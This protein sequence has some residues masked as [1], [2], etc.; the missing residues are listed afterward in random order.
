[1]DI[2][3]IR[4]IGKGIFRPEGVMALDDGT[5]LASDAQ[6]R[7]ARIKR[8]GETGFFGSV[9]G[10]PNGICIDKEGNCIIANIGNG[11]VQSLSPDGN[12]K[13]LMTEADG[14]SITAPNFPFVD[15]KDRL[16]VS[17]STDRETGEAILNPAPDGCIVMIENGSAR[18]VAKDIYFA[19]GIAIDQEEEYFYVAETTKKDVLRFKI[20][21]DG[22]LYDRAVY[23]PPVLDT[24]G[25]PD[26]I[27]F[28]E[29]GNLWITFPMSNAVAY[30]TPQVELRIFLKDP[31]GRFLRQPSNICFG[32]EDRR[33]AFIGSLDG[34]T[35]PYFRVPYPGM[36]LIHQS[37]HLDPAV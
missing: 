19:N 28:D 2:S 22:T 12:H 23:G 26:G 30:I 34:Q 14:K 33:T 37:R 11:Q 17:N 31:E 3:V 5:I 32:W 20:A 13:V 21:E 35:I 6:G 27:A 8:N 4:T 16:W 7:C 1:M 18:I 29:A 10:R 36:K 9:G 24:L 15:S 25:L